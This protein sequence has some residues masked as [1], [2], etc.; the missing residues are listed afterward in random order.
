[1]VMPF[2]TP[3]LRVRE[4]TVSD[5]SF[6][7]TLLNQPSFLQYIGDRGVRT[8]ADAAAFIESRYRQSYRDHG[9]GLY[10]V[11][12]RP[13]AIPLGICG[14]VRRPALHDPDLG[15]ALLPEHEGQGFAFEA[16]AAV[17]EF[18]R[19]TL[20][21]TRVLAVVQADNVRSRALLERLGFVHAGELALVAGEAP[22]LL[23]AHAG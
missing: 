16:A 15:F 18:G 21:L 10:V 13:S 22:V 1:M 5:A 23:F 4:M 3:R 9:Y 6:I 11:E 12:A 17:L 8:D 14:F 2:E 7:G 19:R 20:G